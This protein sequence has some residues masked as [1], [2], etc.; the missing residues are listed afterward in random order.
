MK[1]YLCTFVCQCPYECPYE[2]PKRHSRIQIK[3]KFKIR[4]SQV[5]YDRARIRFQHFNSIQSFMS[6]PCQFYNSGF[7]YINLNYIIT[8]LKSFNIKKY[9]LFQSYNIPLLNHSEREASNSGLNNDHSVIKLLSTID[10]SLS[11]IHIVETFK[12][13][14]T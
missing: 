12:W 6:P 9:S 11:W 13:L 4:L 7:V 14:L 5:V 2:A 10:Q 3:L 1:K 8:T